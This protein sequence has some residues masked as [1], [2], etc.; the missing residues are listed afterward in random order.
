VV[1]TLHLATKAYRLLVL[2]DDD[3]GS[4]HNFPCRHRFA[5]LDAVGNS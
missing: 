1:L 2:V 5:K 4:S 3:V